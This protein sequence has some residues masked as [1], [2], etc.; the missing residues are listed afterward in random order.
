MDAVSPSHPPV[1]DAGQWRPPGAQGPLAKLN[2]ATRVVKGRAPG[3]AACSPLSLAPHPPWALGSGCHSRLVIEP[4]TEPRTTLGRDWIL[5]KKLSLSKSSQTEGHTEATLSSSVKQQRRRE[6]RHL[7][8]CGS[9]LGSDGNSATPGTHV[10]TR[11]RAC[12][13]HTTHSTPHTHSA[14]TCEASRP[15]TCSRSA[16]RLCPRVLQRVDGG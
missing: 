2:L 13:H 15:G 14:C 11:P 8:V 6:R 9:R 1:T 3:A 16:R 10:H 5:R 4:T 7:Q 12:T